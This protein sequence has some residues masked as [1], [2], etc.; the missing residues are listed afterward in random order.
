MTSVS[1]SA[2]RSR[3]P[4]GAGYRDKAARRQ[5]RHP[6]KPCSSTPNG[7]MR[8]GGPSGTS[9]PKLALGAEPS[10]NGSHWTI[11]RTGNVPRS[12]QVLRCISEIFLARRWAA[13]DRV[14]CR[15]FTMSGR[16]DTLAVSPTLSDCCRHGARTSRFKRHR[17]LKRSS[18]LGKS[19]H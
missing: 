19:D 3:F 8:P 6:V 18:R 9:P 16:A 15:L 10:P 1:R 5:G 12:S 14:G 13:G 11:C 4:A 7:S 17:H 2:D